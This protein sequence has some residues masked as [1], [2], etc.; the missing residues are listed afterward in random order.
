MA[1]ETTSAGPRESTS[2]ASPAGSQFDASVFWRWLAVQAQPIAGWVMVVAGALLLVLGYLGT[3]REALVARQLPYL[4][5]GGLGGISLLFLGGVWLG[6]TDIR[7]LNRRLDHVERLAAE[8]HSVLL[9]A[10]EEGPP[11]DGFADDTVQLDRPL[12]ALPTGQSYHLAGCAVVSGKE[13]TALDPG[14]VAERG[15]TPCKLCEP[16]AASV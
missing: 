15:L 10:V 14:D 3:S 1:T 13:T 12:V 16:Q 5:S 11:D 6:L 9:T 4:V 7:R 2:Q 8:L